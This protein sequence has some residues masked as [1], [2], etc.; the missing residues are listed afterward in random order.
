MIYLFQGTVEKKL[1][2]SQKSLTHTCQINNLFHSF[3]RGEITQLE[4][5]KLQWI[6]SYNYGIQYIDLAKA[7][8]EA[9]VNILAQTKNK[10]V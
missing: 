5:L 7:K 9:L 6:L 1:R 4:L 8:C 3:V 2:S 10:I